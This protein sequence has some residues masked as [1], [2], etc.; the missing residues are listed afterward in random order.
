MKGYGSSERR[1][2]GA[3][4][5]EEKGVAKHK[6]PQIK[7]HLIPIPG[8]MIWQVI[9]PAVVLVQENCVC[10]ATVPQQLE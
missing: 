4:A 2:G 6:E 9:L 1:K 3:A 7:N 5:A 10:L 8:R